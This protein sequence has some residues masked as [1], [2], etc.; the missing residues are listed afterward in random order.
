MNNHLLLIGIDRYKNFTGEGRLLTT[1][2]KDVLDFKFVLLEKFYFD[3]DNIVELINENA[4]N[5]NIQN[6]LENFSSTLT[7]T[8]NLIIYFSGH[9]GLKKIQI[10]D[11]GYLLMHFMMI[12]LPG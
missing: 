10:E 12:V 3:S 6:E 2:V 1:C 7:S 5:N 8:D 9:G 4:T 11:I